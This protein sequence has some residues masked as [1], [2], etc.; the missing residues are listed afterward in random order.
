MDKCAFHKRTKYFPRTHRL[1]KDPVHA[2]SVED[3]TGFWYFFLCGGLGH[4]AVGTHLS[5]LTVVRFS[6]A[7]WVRRQ[8]LN[9]FKNP[10]DKIHHLL[11]HLPLNFY[12]TV[13]FCDSK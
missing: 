3:S 8:M 11:K 5:P 6:L 1:G 12:L 7:Q 9:P 2:S 4:P 10:T 13:L